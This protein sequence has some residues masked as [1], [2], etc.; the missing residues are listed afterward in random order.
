MRP[1]FTIATYKEVIFRVYSS[2]L[3]TWYAGFRRMKLF[4]FYI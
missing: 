2:Y 4:V 3:T 1:R